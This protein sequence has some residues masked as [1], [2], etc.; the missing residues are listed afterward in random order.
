MIRNLKAF[1]GV[2]YVCQFCYAGF[3]CRRD[4][5]CKYSCDVCNDAESKI[6][7]KAKYC[8]DCLRY[9]RS[10]YCFVKHKQTGSRGELGAAP[11]DVTKYC[12]KCNRRYHVSVKNPKL[13]KCVTGRCVHCMEDLSPDVD[14]NCYIQPTAFKKIDARYIFFDFETRFENGKHRANFVCAITFDGEEFVAEGHDC[15]DKLLYKFRRPKYSGYTWLAHNAA[16]F[17]NFILL[18]HFSKVA[19]TLKITMTGC[20]LIHMYDE[21]FKQRYID[22]YS[23]IPMRLANTSATLNLN[24]V[25][26]GHFPHAFNKQKITAT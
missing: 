3:T 4:H 12:K 11:C 7:K 9:C 24:T 18:E 16:G 8:V 15:I 6:P 23:F 20:R 1:L 10:D 13:H 14:H 2:P 25:E 22:S 5:R 17:D 26:K 19:I 21:C